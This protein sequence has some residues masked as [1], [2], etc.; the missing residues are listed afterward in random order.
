MLHKQT[1]EVWQHYWQ[2]WGKWDISYTAGGTK[3]EPNPYGGKPLFWVLNPL[4]IL[5]HVQNDLYARLLVWVRKRL[6]TTQMSMNKRLFNKLYD[7]WT[8][9]RVAIKRMHTDN[10]NSQR[11]KIKY[12]IYLYLH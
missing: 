1:P 6:D 10:I 3:N 12:F 9:H 4:N 11:Y 2:S 5:A 7:N 8:E